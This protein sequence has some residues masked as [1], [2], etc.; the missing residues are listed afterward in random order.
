MSDK[1]LMSWL[2]AQMVL[3]MCLIDYNIYY[4]IPL[5][6]GMVVGALVYSQVVIKIL[7][8]TL[9][10]VLST[11]ITALTLNMSTLNLIIFY[12]DV[13]NLTVFGVYMINEFRK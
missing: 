2:N 7:P 4:Y 12:T 8:F 6:Y 13:V 11:F 9:W 10:M 5:L 3:I 1:V